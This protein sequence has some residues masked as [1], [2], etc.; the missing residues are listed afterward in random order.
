LQTKGQTIGAIEAI[1][2]EGTPFDH[3]DLRVLTSLSAPAA[4]AIENAQ[5]FERAQQE[6][7][8]RKRAE[9]ALEEERAL[10]AHR[11]EERTADLKAANAELARAAR[12]KDE[13]LANMSHELRTPLT[14]ILGM[15]E[16]L[17]LNIYG[18]LSEKQ[19]KSVSSIDNSGRHL[20]SLINDILDLS[21][22]E[23]GKLELN[24]GPVSVNSACET[25]LQFVKQMANK[26]DITL[27]FT[28]NKAVMIVQ[29]DERRLKQILVN[30][31]SNAVK[32]TPKGGKVGLEVKESS[33]TSEL[34]K[35]IKFTVWDTG[36]GIPSEEMTELFKPFVQLDSSLSRHHAGTGL[37]LT[38]VSRMVKMHNGK[39]SVESEV[40]HGSCFTISLPVVAEDVKSDL[41]TMPEQTPA[42]P[43]NIESPV[44]LPVSSQETTTPLI[45]VAEDED[46][47]SALF[48]DYLEAVG[49][50]V[51]IAR[52]GSEAVEKSLAESPDLILMD[53]QMPVM[54]GLEATQHLR[55]T[56]EFATIPIIAITARAMAGDRERCLK[57]G[58]N[59]YLSK[60]VNL[61]LLTETIATQLK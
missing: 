17:K 23:A 45:L 61:K 51:I 50:R 52:D 38:L 54:N 7:I 25:S 24:I 1:N 33:E 10:L 47:V 55:A 28:P 57:A 43:I 3:E 42:N 35:Y 2:K 8:E 46:N 22:I 53:I 36:V 32:F 19:F 44:S 5:L 27:S 37:G 29:A 26:K 16:V 11:V 49:Y 18:T 58:A 9:A 34:H 13:F 41:T 48:H 6:I 40:G 21:K 20:L 4:T 14:A 15:C 39:I 12:L 56:A 59:A 31:L 60:P 30:L